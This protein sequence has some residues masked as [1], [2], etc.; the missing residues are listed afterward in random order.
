MF[1]TVFKVPVMG[2]LLKSAARSR[3]I[4]LSP[5]YTCF[6]GHFQTPAGSSQPLWIESHSS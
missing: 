3:T 2:P 6:T 1:Q 4:T 5:H